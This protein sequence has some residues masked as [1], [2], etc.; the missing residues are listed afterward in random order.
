MGYQ[1]WLLIFLIFAIEFIIIS[2]KWI[3]IYDDNMP[4]RFFNKS[5]KCLW[6]RATMLGYILII[7]GI[8]AF[9]PGIIMLCLIQVVLVILSLAG[10]FYSLIAKKAFKDIDKK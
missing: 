4:L 5:L 1:V 2:L 6:K 9:I 8:V 3:N 10:K 7:I